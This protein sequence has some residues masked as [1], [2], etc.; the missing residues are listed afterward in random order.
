MDFLGRA[1]H[2]ISVGERFGRTL[3][4]TWTITGTTGT[5]RQRGGI[6]AMK[7]H[8]VVHEGTKLTQAEGRILLAERAAVPCS[9]G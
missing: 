4:A 3:T 5:P 1:Y 9:T 2:E 6:A 7:A 8:C